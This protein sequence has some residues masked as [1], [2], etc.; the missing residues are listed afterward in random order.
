[1]SS[2]RRF[3]RKPPRVPYDKPPLSLSQ[4]VERLKSRNLIVDDSDKAEFY[5]GQ[6]NYYRF[7]AYCLPFEEEHASHRL[8]AGTHFD[9]VLNLY[10]FD[11]ELRLLVLDAIERLE[12]SLRTQFAYHLSHNYETAHPHL[13]A[14]IFANPMVYARSLS[15]LDSDVKSSKEDFIRH[16]TGK[17]EEELP[18]IWA[19]VELMTMGQLSKW[20]SNIRLRSDRQSIS[21]VYQLNE[22]VMTSFCEHLSLVRNYAAHHA[23]LWNRQLTKTFILPTNADEALIKSLYSRPDNPRQ[24]RKLYNTFVVL[25]HIMNIICGKNQWQKRLKQLIEQHGIST[26]GM[27]FPDDWQDR[28][29]WQ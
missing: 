29:L 1:M 21:L 16:L 3:N 2:S 24:L 25:I 22:K 20:F 12:V 17:Y 6:L 18:P 7:R 13:K 19:A 9:D 14:E 26:R 5:L 23:R 10:I 27:G 8:R 4:Q 11:R 15:K 28:L